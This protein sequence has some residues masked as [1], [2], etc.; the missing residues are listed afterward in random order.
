MKYFIPKLL[1]T[2]MICDRTT[3]QLKKV[4]SPFLVLQFES[5]TVEFDVKNLA[6]AAGK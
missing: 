1:I 6:G 3:E 2:W 5:H 4:H